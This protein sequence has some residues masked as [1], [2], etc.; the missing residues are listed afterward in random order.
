V[1]EIR[2]HGSEGGGAEFNR[3]FLP[4]SGG[5]GTKAFGHRFNNEENTV[6]M[7]GHNHVL[8]SLYM[9]EFLVQFAPPPRCHVPC[10]VESH[11]PIHH[12]AKQTFPVLGAEGHEVRAELGVVVPLEALRMA[13][14]EVR[15]VDHGWSLVVNCRGGPACPPIF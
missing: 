14:V 5:D 3:L 9:L 6:E 10:V 1:R 7:I 11:L 2:T 13:V 15:I 12:L 8:I 4:L